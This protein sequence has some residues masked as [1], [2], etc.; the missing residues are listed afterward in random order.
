MHEGS[1]ITKVVLPER[2]FY[3]NDYLDFYPLLDR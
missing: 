2:S 3:V 1:T